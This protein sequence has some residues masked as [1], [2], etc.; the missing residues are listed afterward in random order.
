M[1]SLLIGLLVWVTYPLYQLYAIILLAIVGMFLVDKFILVLLCWVYSLRWDRTGLGS[2][3]ILTAT[4]LAISFTLWYHI[5]G[6]VR[7]RILRI[8]YH[9]RGVRV[10]DHKKKKVVVHKPKSSQ[11]VPL[12]SD[13][14][15]PQQTTI[16]ENNMPLNT[17]TEVDSPIESGRS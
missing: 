4:T 15:L 3:A 13:N 1:R 9:L 6:Q 11:V 5:F 16:T 12:N 10:S 7:L 2:V 14:T 8:Y 17:I